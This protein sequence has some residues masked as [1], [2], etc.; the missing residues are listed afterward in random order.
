MREF[1]AG[2]P[3]SCHKPTIDWEPIES[4][5][6]FTATANTNADVIDINR[7]MSASEK[8]V[9]RASSLGRRTRDGHIELQHGWYVQSPAAE[10]ELAGGTLNC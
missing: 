2:E 3:F 5:Q 6:P 4:E 7:R 1:P 8:G 10:P 9:C